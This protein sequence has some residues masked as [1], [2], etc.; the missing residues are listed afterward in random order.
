[1]HLMLITFDSLLGPKIYLTVPDTISNEKL[2]ERISD[3]L[4][5]DLGKS[6]FEINI[7]EES[8][9]TFNLY[10]EIPSEIARGGI[11]MALISLIT[12]K[13][14][15]SSLF[16]DILKDTQKQMLEVKDL[17]K[18][19][20]MDDK[21]SDSQV[22]IK[23]KELKNI[24]NQSYEKCEGAISH[25]TIGNILILGINKV[26]KTSIINHLKEKKF[27]SNIK[28]TLALTLI[29]LI[30]D[31]YLFKI[32]DV[33]GQKRLRNQWWSYT[34]SPDAIV[35][36][37]DVND[38]GER[39]DDTKEEFL[40][41]LAKLSTKL[42]KLPILICANKMDLASDK[43][44]LDYFKE[45]LIPKQVKLNYKLQLTSAISGEGLGDG[46]KWLVKN[47]MEIS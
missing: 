40:K 3:F 45:L 43:I 33:G 8:L 4:N 21:I 9:K 39:L 31:T 38:K 13:N 46:F 19:F 24:L 37:F 7:I 27:S 25:S 47:L 12:E 29:E 20:Y 28:P 10:I 26:G 6:F 1:M 44:D 42:E 30:I 35:F 41:I 34:S 5:L 32:V 2:K 16:Y 22:E 36:V 11:E 17:Y 14:Y 15:K 18:G 23:Y